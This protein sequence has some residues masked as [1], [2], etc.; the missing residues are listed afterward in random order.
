MPRTR[1]DS[2][3]TEPILSAEAIEY[4]FDRCYDFVYDN[5]VFPAS[6]NISG[7]EI[8]PHQK[9][10]MD[11]ISSYPRV[12]VESGH[13][14]GKSTCL[15]WIGKWFLAT[16][17]NTLG[18]L[19]KVVCLA[20][21]FH[22]LYDILWPEFR[23]WL[24]LSR[25]DELF[26]KRTDEI[27]IKGHKDSSFIRARSPKE[28]DNVQGFHAA[29][30]MWIVDEA[31][32]I[33]KELVWETIEG[34]FTEEDN[35]IIIA[36]QHTTITGYCHDAFNKDKDSWRQLRFDSE[37]S[38]IA[39]PEYAQRIA[40]K[41]GK[42][43]DIYRVRVK[44]MA[45]KGNPDSFIQLEQVENAKNREVRPI[46]H[47][48][49]GVDCARFG[50]DLTVVTTRSGNHVFPQATLD[51]SDTNDIVN[52]TLKE[53]RKYRKQ[54]QYVGRVD[55]KVDNTGGYGAGAVD[56]L[57]KNTEDNIRVIPINF[58][59]GGNE[60][61]EDDISVMWGE[62]RDKIEHIQLPHSDELTEELATR[63]FV[64]SK[65]GRTQIE[66]KK[67]FKKDYEASPDRS[68]SLVL[69]FTT[70]AEKVRVFANYIATNPEHS[71]RYR[72][73]WSK[74]DSEK[75]DVYGVLYLDKDYSITGNFYFWNRHRRVLRVYS[76]LIHPNPTPQELVHD[77]RAKAQVPL[78]KMNDFSVAVNTIYGNDAMFVRGKDDIV[79]KMLKIGV[80]IKNNPSYDEPGAILHVNRMFEQ[81]QIL[82]NSDLEETDRQYRN[83]IIENYKPVNGF[84]LCR[85][86][87]I[88]VNVLKEKGLLRIEPEL[89]AY[90]PRKRRILE[91]LRS[92][93]I[94]QVPHKGVKQN[95][96]SH[97]DYLAK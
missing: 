41:Y 69:A 51:R 9:A 72:I 19:T 50:D 62:L 87:C 74:V 38:P 76:Q 1:D 63:R 54:V 35:R 89:G 95:R 81:N 39:K 73:D 75:I 29:H 84:P 31:F 12:C 61:Y 21:T 45:P 44:G 24:P 42:N 32:G 77:L 53:L 97:D 83:W 18:Y 70:K 88:I 37:E 92:L 47:L 11:E 78:K 25:L 60:E 64:I 3:K 59:T 57:N 30:L 7:I 10:L 8:T 68:D 85:S 33:A 94:D 27:F 4:Y 5:I 36:G 40:R 17:H 20:P 71:K 28:P 86:L 43:S 48:E 15:A 82:V 90:S 55:I 56:A 58:G 67:N 52:L 93:D 13:G 66:P 65:S 34:S 2:K 16:R 6:R 96:R 91:H 23:R 80:R 22:Q 14:T 26:D 46:N 79:Y 49:I